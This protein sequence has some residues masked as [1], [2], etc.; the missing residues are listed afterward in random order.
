MEMSFSRGAA[1]GFSAFTVAMIVL[2]GVFT[3]YAAPAD[4]K[5]QF[6]FF[7][8]VHVMIF[9]GFGFL[10]SFLHRGGFT[11]TSHAFLVAAFSV[12][13][14]LLN[15]G[16]WARAIGDHPW[17]NITLSIEEL[18]NVDF[19]AG[20]ILISFG[21]LLGRVS[22]GQLLLMAIIEV[23][24]YCIN[25]A[26][27]MEKLHAIDAGGVYFI[28]MF[29][30]FFGLA[31]SLALERLKPSRRDVDNTA[32]GSTRVTDTMAMVGTLFLFVYW[33]TFNAAPLY[34]STSH[35]RALV[36]TYLSIAMSVI[37]TFLTCILI[38]QKSKI[39]MVEVQNAT[40]AGGVAMGAAC[41][42]VMTPV[43]AI[44]SGSAAGIVSV[45]G[46][47]FVTPKLESLIGLRDTCGVLNLHGMPSIIGAV[48]SAI[49]IGAAEG[50]KYDGTIA[51]VFPKFGDR[52]YSKQA[53]I[54]M[55]AM[56]ITIGFAL[57]GGLIA[58]LILSRMPSLPAF[59]EDVHEYTTPEEHDATEHGT[60]EGVVTADQ[61]VKF[62]KNEE[63]FEMKP[64]MPTGGEP[65]EPANN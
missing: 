28:H 27:V 14:A 30:A 18:L 2:F 64:R 16:F 42:L 20:A 13:W 58:G 7:T 32:F 26:V 12:M 55:A 10:M 57:V 24:I 11:A 63:D 23:V 8:D 51:Q 19:C 61:E 22:V 33:P 41:G 40:L 39:G 49:A 5:G 43:G 62:H 47:R 59:F 37:T 53:G 25:E 56:F 44:I 35:D 9:V 38:D 45:L 4:V 48:V 1:V 31:C 6:L 15:R 36:N 65:A 50:A 34:A 17:S 52:S 3:E 29:G 46:Y 60:P 21:A 54:Q